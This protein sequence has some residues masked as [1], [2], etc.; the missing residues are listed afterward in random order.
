ML[1][2]LRTKRNAKIYVF[3]CSTPY[4]IYYFFKI[5]K[6]LR[7]QKYKRI[8]NLLTLPKNH[9]IYLV[10]TMDNIR[11]SELRQEYRLKKLDITEVNANPFDQFSLWFHEALLTVPYEPNAMTLAT[12]STDGAPSAR[13]VLLKGFDENGFIFYTNYQSRKG[14]EIEAN[15]KVALLFTWYELQRQVRIEGIAQKIDAFLSDDYFRSRPKSSQ[16]GAILSPQSEVISSRSVLEEKEKELAEKYAE[17]EFLPRPPHWGGY[18][19]APQKIE[20]WQGRPSR[21]HD[22]IQYV[23]TEGVDWHLQRLAP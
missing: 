20:F 4:L 5:K 16:I 21:L 9:S 23:L 22:R 19:V 8:S 18:I 17:D 15:P 1:L 14:K 11:L 6:N 7:T 3:A 13:V 2:L 10:K 12:T